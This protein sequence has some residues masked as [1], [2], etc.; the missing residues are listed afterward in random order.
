M[1]TSVEAASYLDMRWR[2]KY[3]IADLPGKFTGLMALLTVGL[4]AM[5]AA[6]GAEEES[7]EV[8]VASFSSDSDTK[9]SASAAANN[10]TEEAAL[11]SCTPFS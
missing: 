11:L 5:K 10:D 6:D 7:L 1:R 9:N 4:G 2:G 3:F 8:D